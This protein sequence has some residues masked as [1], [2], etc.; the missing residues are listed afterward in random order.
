MLKPIPGYEGYYSI[1]DFGRVFSL[2][3][4]VK[5]S[6]K[7]NGTW[8]IKTKIVTPYTCKKTGK[9]KVQLYKNGKKRTF[10]IHLLMKRAGFKHEI[11]QTS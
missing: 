11:R 10:F 3:R 4:E 1:D 8:V 5:Y 7:K 9:P 2:S 6:G